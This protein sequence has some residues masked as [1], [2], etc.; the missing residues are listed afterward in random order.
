M[1]HTG[2]AQEFKRRFE[3]PILRGRDADATDE[4]HKKGEEK[5]QEVVLMSC[6]CTELML[7]LSNANVVLM[8]STNAMLIKC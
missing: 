8:Q 6:Y 3:T 7:L 2:T 4:D 5:L 1:Y